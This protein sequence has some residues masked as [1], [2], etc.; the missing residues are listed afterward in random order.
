MSLP[1]ENKIAVKSSKKRKHTD[2]EDQPK[3]TKSKD[4]SSKRR[5]ATAKEELVILGAESAADTDV[6]EQADFV[7]LVPEGAPQTVKL[8]KQKKEKKSKSDKKKTDGEPKDETLP[9]EVDVSGESTSKTEEAKEESAEQG[10]EEAEKTAEEP[11]PVTKKGRFI[12]FIG[13]HILGAK[14]RVPF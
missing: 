4:K 11:E 12:V 8:K 3:T 5:K 6:K 14:P 9:A 1:A 13:M 7:A 10:V 2:S